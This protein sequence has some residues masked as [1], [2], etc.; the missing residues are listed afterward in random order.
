RCWNRG[1]NENILLSRHD[2]NIDDN[3][4]DNGEVVVV[5]DEEENSDGDGSCNPTSTYKFILGDLGF[6]G[7]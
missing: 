1:R 6:Y 3:K 4:L 2:H 5:L 7:Y